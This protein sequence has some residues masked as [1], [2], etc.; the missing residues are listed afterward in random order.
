MYVYVSASA[1]R[2]RSISQ[3]HEMARAD[4]K[5]NVGSEE[6][7]TCA[8][9]MATSSVACRAKVRCRSGCCCAPRKSVEQQI[10]EVSADLR[11]RHI[12]GIYIDTNVSP[13]SKDPHHPLTPHATHAASKISLVA[14]SMMLILAEARRMSSI[15]SGRYCSNILSPLHQGYGYPRPARTISAAGFYGSLLAPSEHGCRACEPF[16]L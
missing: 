12:Y 7:K 9:A 10:K 6:I 3:L 1:T 8:V 5:A 11:V 14:K 2:S 13:S 4:T 15:R 16:P